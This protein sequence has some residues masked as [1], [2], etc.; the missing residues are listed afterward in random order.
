[1]LTNT[2]FEADE[3][4]VLNIAVSDYEGM[5]FRGKPVP[6]LPAALKDHHRSFTIWSKYNVEITN[7][8]DPK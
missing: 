6:S 7:M 4:K 2:L 8:L 3:V 5:E 1:M